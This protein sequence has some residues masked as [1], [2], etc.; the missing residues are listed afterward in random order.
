MSSQ[1]G[2]FDVKD[3]KQL[4]FNEF[5]ADNPVFYRLFVR[6]TL[7]AINAGRSR[8]SAYAVRERIR[9]YTTIETRSADEFKI[10]NNHIPFY[11]RLF[12]RDYPQH[13]GFFEKRCAVADE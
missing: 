12:E 13:V 4:A 7:Q 2:L 9:W 3:P 6:F 5:H 10:N 11:V 8:F 1:P